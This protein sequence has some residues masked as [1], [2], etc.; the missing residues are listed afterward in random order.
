M[1]ASYLLGQ[2]AT[3]DQQ[4]VKIR[5]TVQEVV[6]DVRV[7]DNRG[8]QLKNLKPNELEI[9]EN[10]VRREIQSFRLVQGH[11][12]VQQ[13]GVSPEVVKE[14]TAVS[15]RP[16]APPLSAV[17]LICLVFQNLDPA[18]RKYA[19]EAA[20]EFLQSDLPPETWVAVFNLSSGL[21]VLHPFTRN[22]AELIAAAEKAFTTTTVD[23]ASAA[24][25]LISYTPSMS[26]VEVT[27]NGTPASGGTV[28]AGVKLSGGELNQQAVIGAEVASGPIAGY[29]RGERTRDRRQFGRLE[30]MR[31]TDQIMAMISQLGLLPGHKTVLLFSPGLATTGDPERFEM[32]LNKAHRASATIYTIDVNGLTQNSNVLAGNAA[33]K[34]AAGLSSSQ[35]RVRDTPGAMAEKM[36]Q[37]DYVQDAVRTT[38]TQASLRQLSEGTGAFLI[39]NTN[40][41][42]KPF[43]RVMEDLDTH[44]EVTYR[45]ASGSYDGRLR[46]IEVRSS[47]PGIFVQ[48][49][50]GYFSLPQLGGSD[51][52]QPAEMA[53]LTA[54]STKP[55]PHGFDFRT[56]AIQ[57]RPGSGGT[58]HSIVFEVPASVLAT[59]PDPAGKRHHLHVSLFALI[60]NQ[61][62]EVVDMV[63]QD[64]P[65][66]VPDEQVAALRSSTVTFTR[67]VTLASGHYTV[68]AAAVDQESKRASTAV[69]RVDSPGP[70]GIGLSGVVLV[71]RYEAVTG[72]ADPAN[73]FEI[74]TKPQNRR[75]VP[76]L[77]ASFTTDAHPSAYFV[78]YPDGSNS[79]KPKIQ[80]ESLVDGR[81]VASQ[82]ADLPAADSTGAIPMIVRAAVHPGSCELR[83]TAIQGE[84]S[85]SRSLD[86][87]VSS[88]GS[89]AA[90]H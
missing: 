80:I 27:M 53:G 62:G 65:Y 30:G 20:Q 19:V 61:N 51:V 3:E 56:S 38:D 6:V 2:Q 12:P 39:A 46:S 72:P 60:K 18:T 89:P 25:A 4:P 63:S 77:Q 9:Y 67:P 36:K 31:E 52:L 78:V 81:T 26:T 11:T 35:A 47:R 14:K 24:N 79:A 41:L 55:L 7:R 87:I 84:Q 17:N 23:F 45:P 57:F 8:R 83:V 85:I 48:S 32:I 1:F 13:A 59:T 69:L 33:L 44:Y 34:Y 50:A 71:Q 75:V 37:D 15:P 90:R 73:P 76:E 82:T 66:E 54:L 43:Q 10:G 64:A 21:T 58:Q 49:R 70:H 5:S 29:F 40:D 88:N 16:A 86:Y 28:T 22:R 74:Q 42:R 68:E